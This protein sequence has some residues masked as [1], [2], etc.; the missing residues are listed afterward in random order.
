VKLLSPHRQRSLIVKQIYIAGAKR[1][2]FSQPI[3]AVLRRAGVK[4]HGFGY[5][6]TYRRW[7]RKGTLA[8]SDS[9][10]ASPQAVALSGMGT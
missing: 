10:P 5:F 8:V 6:H 1:N 4:L 2:D 7:E 3:P 9:D